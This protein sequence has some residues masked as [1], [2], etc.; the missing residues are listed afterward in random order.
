MNMI[1]KNENAITPNVLRFDKIY[2]NPDVQVAYAESEI[3]SKD[4]ASLLDDLIDYLELKVDK[5]QDKSE[6]LAK[7]QKKF[8]KHRA[9]Y[10]ALMRGAFCGSQVKFPL[11]AALLFLKDPSQ[12]QEIWSFSRRM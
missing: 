9:C 6:R 1:L 5:I 10:L 8:E 3:L 2:W 7:G 4:I 12:V 11:F